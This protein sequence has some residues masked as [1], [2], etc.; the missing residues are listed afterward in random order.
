MEKPLEL[1]LEKCD[2]IIHAAEKANRKL[3]VAQSHRY[4]EG[5]AI[6][7]R[8]L[9]EGAIGNLLMCRDVLAGPGYR[10]HNPERAW[11]T[12]PDLYGTGGLIAWGVHDTDRLRWWFNSEVDAVFA[13]SYNLR[14][15][16]PGD[17]TSNML[18]L[19]FQ[20]GGSAHLIYS[21]ALPPPG[22][23]GFS[24]NAQLIGDEGLMDVDPYNQVKIARKGSG[25]WETVYDIKTVDDPRQKA[26]ADE[27]R[28]FI[29]CIVN[30]TKPPVSGADGRAAVEIAL[31][32]Y[33]SSET[34]ESVKLPLL[35]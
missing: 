28:D 19:S 1:T 22:W 7:K 31:A 10:K 2:A 13:R 3:M 34:G 21:E 32:A 25:Q 24:C 6:A 29:S 35:P 33:R 26:F 12:N 17:I 8:L 15:D 5:G 20:N 4:W 14:T 9:D 18:M 16:V 27:V 23:K 11:F 30:N